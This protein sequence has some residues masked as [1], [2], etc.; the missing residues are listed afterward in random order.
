MENLFDVHKEI[1]PWGNYILFSENEKCTT[2]ILFV[3]RNECL[4]MQFHQKRDQMYFLLDPFIIEYSTKPVPKEIINNKKEIL[5]FM[6]QFLTKET[7]KEGS[8]FKFKKRVIHRSIY[9]GKREYGRY[10]DISFGHNSEEDITR[11]V[12]KYGREWLP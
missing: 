12:D 6:D 1:R 9:V 7:A 2:K 5:K 4:S 10:L 8:I 3:K 11:I